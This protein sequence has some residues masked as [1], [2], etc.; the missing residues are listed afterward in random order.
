MRSGPATTRMGDHEHFMRQALAVARRGLS[1]GEMPIGAVVAVG[2]DIISAEH[3][4]EFTTK[5]LLVHADLLALL[6]MDRVIGRDRARATLYVTL[7]PC[8]MCLGAAFA[9]R[10]PTVV[11]GLESPTDGGTTAFLEWDARRGAS[12]LPGYSVPQLH[13]G[14]LRAESADLFREYAD[15]K[16][17]G[18]TAA[19]ARDLARLAQR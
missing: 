9:S 4:Q 7:E 16:R 3:T 11:Y 15:S 1:R 17:D 2:D 5:R 19:W 10:V 14:V 8:V 13:G 18:W 12:G 6:E